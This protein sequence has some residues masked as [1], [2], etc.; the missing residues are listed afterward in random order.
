MG[1]RNGQEEKRINFSVVVVAADHQ[2]M[3]EEGS[4]V[5]EMVRNP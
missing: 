1:Y 4:L 5:K 2:I 3:S